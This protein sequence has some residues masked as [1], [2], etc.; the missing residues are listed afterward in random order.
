MKY[1]NLAPKDTA[2][3]FATQ[4]SCLMALN[5]AYR[6]TGFKRFQQKLAETVK[7]MEDRCFDPENGGVYVPLSVIGNP[8]SGIKYAA[9]T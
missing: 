2:K 4:I 3:L 1:E 8:H 5:V 6:L 9:P 7:I